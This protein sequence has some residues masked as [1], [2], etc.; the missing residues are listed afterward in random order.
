MCS[1]R[2]DGL[3]VEIRRMNIRFKLLSKLK[4]IELEK[5]QKACK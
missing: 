1:P 4:R 3:R 2:N 5:L